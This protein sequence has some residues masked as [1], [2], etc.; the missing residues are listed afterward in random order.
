MIWIRGFFFSEKSNISFNSHSI[1]LRDLNHDPP[2]SPSRDL[3]YTVHIGFSFILNVI[4]GSI[5]WSRSFSILWRISADSSDAGKE[6]RSRFSW[7]W[8]YGSNTI[9]GRI[10]LRVWSRHWSAAPV[11]GHQAYLEK[12]FTFSLY[13]R[14]SICKD[15]QFGSLFQ[16]WTVVH[17]HDDIG[18]LELFR[19]DQALI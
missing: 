8:F 3:F 17:V 13:G 6:R 4:H 15:D 5:F 18:L 7:S 10:R 1:Y 2:Y 16:N 11:F 12:S 9:N 19:L 14:A